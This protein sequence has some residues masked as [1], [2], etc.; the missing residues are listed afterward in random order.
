MACWS[1]MSPQIVFGFIK[2][3]AWEE[4]TAGAA[5]NEIVDTDNDTKIQVEKMTDEDKIRFDVVGNEA[6]I[7]NNDG[8]VGIGVNPPTS[9]LDVD[10]TVTS[11]GLKMVD[12]NQAAGKI[13]V[14]DSDGLGAWTNANDGLP[15]P[16][17]AAIIPIRYHGSYLYV[18]PTDNAT[19]VNWTTAQSTCFD[20]NALGFSDWY[21]PAKLELDAMHKQS[22]LITGL[23]QTG[24]A[25]YWSDTELNM[26]SAYTQRL[27]YG[28]SDPDPKIDTVGHNCRCVRKI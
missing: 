4:L 14:S 15:V 11:V 19:G 9:K 6:M 22:Y 20:L 3:I 5:S 23:S 1:S 17:T 8:Q 21:L 25:K 7:I 18:H 28:G 10:G 13:M 12:G 26:D 2:C 24:T 27:D 16:D